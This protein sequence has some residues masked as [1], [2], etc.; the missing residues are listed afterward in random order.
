MLVFPGGSLCYFYE[1]FSLDITFAPAPAATQITFRITEDFLLVLIFLQTDAI[2]ALTG[3]KMHTIQ[4]M[5]EQERRN[6]EQLRQDLAC[7][8]SSKRQQ[9]L[10]SASKRLA[11][12]EQQLSDLKAGKVRLDSCTVY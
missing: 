2:R 6:V 4:L 11:K 10:E 12:L 9:E 3:E 5:A 1:I 7:S 8:N